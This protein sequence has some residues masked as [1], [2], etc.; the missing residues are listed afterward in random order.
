MNSRHRVTIMSN[1]QLDYSGYS[2]PNIIMDKKVIRTKT[3]EIMNK[4]KKN[5]LSELKLNMLNDQYKNSRVMY[6]NK[7]HGNRSFHEDDNII[8]FDTG[9]LNKSQSFEN[10]SPKSQNASLN[11]SK[12]GKNGIFNYKEREIDNKIKR[13]MIGKKKASPY[14]K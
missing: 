10:I 1:G 9:K 11:N 8:T 7:R 6:V 3:N 2:N 14:I 4:T 12:S 5:Q 13:V